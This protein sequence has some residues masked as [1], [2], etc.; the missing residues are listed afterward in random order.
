MEAYL[1]TIKD[2][3]S[4]LAAISVILNKEVKLALIFNGIHERYRYLAIALEQQDLDFDE[5]TARLIE[6]AEHFPS[7]PE[8]GLVES[9]MGF[10]ARTG[11]PIKSGSKPN[12]SFYCG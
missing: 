1:R 9:S 4:E 5:L 11:K 6:E 3:L 2:K 12:L 10:L 8:S 7:S